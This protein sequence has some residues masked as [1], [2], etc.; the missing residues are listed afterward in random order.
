MMEFLHVFIQ[1]GP[2][3]LGGGEICRTSLDGAR[4]VVGELGRL[5]A[6]PVE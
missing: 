2:S 6:P 4:Q 1:G 5:V 3:N